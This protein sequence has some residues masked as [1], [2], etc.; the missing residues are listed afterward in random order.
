MGNRVAHSLIHDAPYIAI[1]YRGNDHVIEFNEIHSVCYESND[2]GAVYGGNNWSM[3]GTVIRHN[4]IHHVLSLSGHGCNGVYLDDLFS[5]N[6]LYGNVFHRVRRAAFIGGGRDNVVENN[7]F[8]D[9]N[10]ALHVDS[11][12]LGK[13]NYGATSSQPHKLKQMPYQQPPW[14]TRY[15]KLVNMLD[16][17]PAAPKG[18]LIV[19]NVCQGGKWD[20]V[21]SGARPYITQKDNLIVDDLRFVDPEHLDF[22][23]RD[24]SPAFSIR[25]RRIPFGKIGLRADEHR[26][27]WP[28]KHTV[29][30]EPP[31]GPPPRRP[32]RR[33]PPP[34]FNV[35]RVAAPVR[36]D[37][38][39]GSGE[40]RIAFAA[41]GI[42]AQKARKLRLNINVRR[43]AD[44]SWMVWACT[45]AEIWQVS[46]AG[47]LVLIK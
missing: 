31:P 37:G 43:T 10:P 15:P 41:A 4:F 42:D 27:S 19:R 2:A 40:W 44:L 35:A 25:F 47:E 3:R 14:N 28:V 36:V 23:F 32:V 24:D 29:L 16:D 33:G 17:E 9:C 6:T 12:G 5:G 26:A 34:V 46:A 39:I 38:R 45:G 13:Y 1:W 20:G 11:R 18:N 8:V 21:R 30:R 22:R 7:V